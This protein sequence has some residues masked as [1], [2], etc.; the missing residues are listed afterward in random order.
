[1]SVNREFFTVDG[2][3]WNEPSKKD[4]IGANDIIYLIQWTDTNFEPEEWLEV[5]TK[6]NYLE[7]LDSVK[8]IWVNFPKHKI[9]VIRYDA[10]YLGEYDGIQFNK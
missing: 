1:M 8:N 10:I 4:L 5:D 3:E 9:R 7:M 6:T 2:R